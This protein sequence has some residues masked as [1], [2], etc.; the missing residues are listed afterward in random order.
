MVRLTQCDDI[1]IGDRI[2]KETLGTQI[3]FLSF[4]FQPHRYSNANTS[5][6]ISIF[7]T[8]PGDIPLEWIYADRPSD[9]T[10]DCCFVFLP[11]GTSL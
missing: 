5:R 10:W 1:S 7:D 9:L 8:N 2:S 6:L 4:I 11:W 3:S